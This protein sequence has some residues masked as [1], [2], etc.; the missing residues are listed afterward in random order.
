VRLAGNRR[1][2]QRLGR[3]ATGCELP[4]DQVAPQ[5][6]LFHRQERAAVNKRI[7][8][9]AQPESDLKT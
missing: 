4:T 1:R 2:A 7:G 5:A 9:T 6:C 8:A 3:I